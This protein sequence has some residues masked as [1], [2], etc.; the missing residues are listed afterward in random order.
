MKEVALLLLTG[1]LT[2][3]SWDLRAGEVASP[4]VLA[5]AHAELEGIS[6]CG[7]CHGWLGRTPDA[8][9]LACHEDVGRRVDAAL[10]VHGGF[11]GDCAGCHPDHH[12][13]EAD[14]MGLDR[15]GFNHDQTLFRLR[16]AHADVACDDCHVQ[17]RPPRDA[18]F[19]PIGI[20]YET[21]TACH[22]DPHGERLV[23]ARACSDCHGDAAWSATLPPDATRGAGFDHD[24]DTRFALDAAHAAVPCAACHRP[25]AE[26]PPAREC[27]A[28]HGDA[29]ALLSGAFAGERRAPDP[30][31]GA[32]VCRDCHPAALASASLPAYAAVC[33]ECHPGSY[34]SLLATRR[35]LLDEALVV[36]A[37]H[38]PDARAR[39]LVERLARSGLHHAELAEAL[40]R[41]LAS[42][43]GA[44]TSP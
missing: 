20:P 43:T 27:A 21:C 7:Q 14:L 18:A 15:E 39:S 38:A 41:S 40:A 31:A 19:H 23:R 9:C 12:G 33:T 26:A 8:D 29:A 17:A 35:A 30:H 34:A 22:Q 5:R 28:C 6:Q 36:A 24:A 3:P 2:A 1:L 42:G 16:G 32:V 13:L 10:G 44:G 37:A 11:Q 4:G 25:E